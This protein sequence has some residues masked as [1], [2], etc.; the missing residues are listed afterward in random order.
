MMMAVEV[1]SPVRGQRSV[2]PS[3]VE[4]RKMRAHVKA[5]TEYNYNVQCIHTTHILLYTT[6]IYT[7]SHPSTGD[8]TWHR[9]KPVLRTRPV[10]VHS[11]LQLRELWF[12]DV[13]MYK[14]T[15]TC[16]YTLTVPMA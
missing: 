7:P 9:S 13:Y 1:L 4:V 5:N 6:R 11:C 3:S 12:N 8:E 2:L 15:G 10:C 14:Y 16:S